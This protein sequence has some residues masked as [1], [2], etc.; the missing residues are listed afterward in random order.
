MNVNSTSVVGKLSKNIGLGLM[1]VLM[2]I[3]GFVVYVLGDLMVDTVTKAFE[4][5]EKHPVSPKALTLLEGK[6]IPRDLY[7]KVNVHTEDTSRIALQQTTEVKDPV[8]LVLD[9]RNGDFFKYGR[10]IIPIELLEKYWAPSAKQ[11][12]PSAMTVILKDGD[13]MYQNHYASEKEPII[14]AEL[15][16]VVV[17]HRLLDLHLRVNPA[18]KNNSSDIMGK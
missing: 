18:V 2:C 3:M 16:A 7:V 4:R 17:A 15:C 1:I 10:E 9:Y 5:F 6:E 13:V 11:F 8:A 12:C 14:N